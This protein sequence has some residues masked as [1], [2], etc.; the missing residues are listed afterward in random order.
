MR[1]VLAGAIRVRPQVLE[2]D[3]VTNIL[4]WIIGGLVGGLVGAA[5]WV[6]VSVFLNFELG[7]IAWGIGVLTGLGVSIAGQGNTNFMSGVLAAVIAIGC[8]GAGK[9]FTVAIQAQRAGFGGL[10]DEELRQASMAS[11]ADDVIVQWEGP[12]NRQLA[13]P[14]GMTYDEAEWP[15][16]YPP[17]VVEEVAARW[18]EMTTQEQRQLS[19]YLHKQF[20]SYRSKMIW[21]FFLQSFS[22]WDGLWALFAVGSAYK[23]GSNEDDD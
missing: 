9:Y 20:K 21:D 6:V 18:A 17:E 7:L 15:D 8:I 19:K 12:D 16:D 2:G 5:V 13:W 3:L 10:T 22:P 14:D 23:L 11:V 1:C 4:R